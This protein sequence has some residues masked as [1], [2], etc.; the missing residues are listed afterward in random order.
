MEEKNCILIVDDDTATLMELASI[1]AADYKIYT[2]KDGPAALEKASDALPD[3]ILLDVIMPDLNG[4][5]VL[6]KLKENEK[7][8]DI[9]V[10]F[11]TGATDREAEIRG[12][13]TGAVDYIHK[14]LNESL[15]K[16]RVSHQI[17]LLTQFRKIEH[18]SMI[19]QLTNLPNRRSFEMRINEEWDRALRE[20]MP[21][22]SLMIDIDHFKKYNDMYGHQQGDAALVAVAEM[23]TTS[24][25]RPADFAARWG[26][27]EFIIL[28]P[29]TESRGAVDVAETVRKHAESLEIPTSDGTITKITISVGVNTHKPGQRGSIDKFV[30]WT[31]MAL[32][33]AKN[34][35]RNKVCVFKIPSDQKISKVREIKQNIIFIVDDNETNL[36][37]AEDA[38]VDLYRVIAL[39]SAAKMFDAL[40]KFKPDM[41]LLDIEMPEMNGF[42]AIKILKGN[43]MYEEIP[44]IFLTGLSDAESEADGI[45]LGAVDF[46]MK[47]FTKPVLLNRIRKHLDIDELVRERTRQLAHRT[48]QLARRT[49]QLERLKNGIVYTLAD[50]VENRDSNTGGHIDR[51]S[52]YMS[53]LVD[54]MISREVY[55]SEMEEWNFDSVISSARLHDIGKIAIPD[56][57]LN[58][59]DKLTDEEFS[60]I[61]SHPEVGRRMIEQMEERTG[62]DG[63]LKNAILFAA[64]HHEKWNGKGYPYGLSG[65]DI[66]LHGRIMAVIDVYDALVS[67]RPYKKAFEHEKAVRIIMEDAGSHFDP[68]IAEVFDNISDD[69]L[70]AKERFPQ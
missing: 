19:D 69:I 14:P 47:P 32:Y 28:L 15:V 12:L 2:V 16:L 66:P 6:Q 59:P 24:L 60:I 55:R 13:A 62:D 11:I 7:T 65:S 33:D 9:P 10:I 30:S 64:Y 38:L 50:V 8:K 40:K 58:K 22:S 3:L 54:A 52:V 39:T 37:A 26:G 67:D 53:I 56:T 48:E 46:I 20:H 63:F 21:I 35:G 23:F 61:Q 34:Q 42:E 45:E 68:A 27:E 44:V 17:Q 49:E 43:D 4:F 29:N 31:D 57:V 18:L 36:T 41:I 25:R 51:T 70:A 5:E 1:L